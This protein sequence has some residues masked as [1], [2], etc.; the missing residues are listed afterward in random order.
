MRQLLK[1]I[2]V[3]LLAVLVTTCNTSKKEKNSPSGTKTTLKKPS[4]SLET[5]HT[6]I[7]WT[8]Y[9]FTD[10]L[11]VSG[12]FD[13]FKLQLKTASGSI[14]ELLRNAKITINTQSVNSNNEIRDAKLRTYFFTFFR[15]D[16]IF[17]EIM[18]SR[19]GVGRLALK[20]NDI[21][22][23]TVFEYSIKKDTLQLS[24]HVDL[25][26][27]NGAEALQT[28]NK[29]CYDLHTGTDGFSKLWPDVAVIF[30][31]PIKTNTPKN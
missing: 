5:E 13:E 29:E 8:A 16:T 17:G 15:T 28:L 24:T 30:K 18:D 25:L 23:D 9:K 1:T 12:T 7:L 6:S 10:K 21:T 20:M 19:N 31:I 3:L 22:N 11:G 27:W 4:Y 26:S 2:L 14:D